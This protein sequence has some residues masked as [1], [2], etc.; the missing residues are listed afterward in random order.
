MF[1]PTYNEYFPLQLF[2]A[3]SYRAKAKI[4][5][6]T[7]RKRSLR[8]LCFHRCLSTGGEVSVQG[9]LC[10]GDVFQMMYSDDLFQMANQCFGR[11]IQGT[12]SVR[13]K[14][15]KGPFGAPLSIKRPQRQRQAL[16]TSRRKI[17]NL[18]VNNSFCLNPD[19][20]KKMF[21]NGLFT[22]FDCDCDFYLNKWV[23]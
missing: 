8:R 20:C 23:S 16:Q 22:R 1:A 5:L 12:G 19:S 17:L 6:I 21:P 4:Y 2:K 13:L 15:T 9:G 10:D 7:A 11:V 3:H 18:L 14:D